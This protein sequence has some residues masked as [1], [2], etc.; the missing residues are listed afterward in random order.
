VGGHTAGDR[1]ASAEA[2]TSRPLLGQDRPQGLAD[3]AG[4]LFGHRRLPFV[5]RGHAQVC[6]ALIGA[7][8]ASAQPKMEAFPA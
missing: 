5:L 4:L 6:V 2:T 8:P 3:P 1:D 7:A